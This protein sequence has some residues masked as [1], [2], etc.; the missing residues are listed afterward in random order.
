MERGAEQGELRALGEGRR[1]CRG[2][3]E[4]LLL[5]R[6][7]RRSA[8][9]RLCVA[10]HRGES[11]VRSLAVPNL[12][13]HRHPR[14]LSRFR[15]STLARRRRRAAR[16]LRWMQGAQ[17]RTAT[18]TRSR[19]TSPT[20]FCPAPARV[21]TT[22]SRRRPASPTREGQEDCLRS[23]RR[24]HRR[25]ERPER[26][27][28]CGALTRSR[29]R[30]RTR[31]NAGGRRGMRGARRPRSRLTAACPP[32]SLGAARRRPLGVAEAEGGAGGSRGAV[33]CDVRRV[34][35]TKRCAR[36]GTTGWVCGLLVGA[37]NHFLWS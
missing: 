21:R 29:Q 32:Q 30:C 33:P 35:R 14:T 24:T 10:R 20:C 17:R 8:D 13:S 11:R 6:E 2:E 37:P 1:Q 31:A 12:L 15:A 28:K 34:P 27:R 9:L 16:P 22:R 23:R 7:V 19:R 3:L 5:L 26:E 4:G 36:R 18:T 25:R